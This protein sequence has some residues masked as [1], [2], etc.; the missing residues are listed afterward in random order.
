MPLLLP[1][2]TLS[3][4]VLIALMLANTLNFPLL[5]RLSATIPMD[6]SAGHRTLSVADSVWLVVDADKHS[7]FEFRFVVNLR[8]HC[9]N[10]RP[11]RQ[12]APVGPLS[13]LRGGRQRFQH[14]F[15]VV[16]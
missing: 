12:E 1:A 7:C 13:V 6:E 10:T 3:E 14:L 4:L 8:R 9:H 16:K 15:F 5:L 11:Q 2:V